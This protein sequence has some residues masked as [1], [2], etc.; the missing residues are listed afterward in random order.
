MSFW[1]NVIKE[2][3]YRGISRKELAFSLGMNNMTIH[4]AIERDSMPAADTAL[5]I[6]KTLGVS[7][8][9]LL[10]MPSESASENCDN[11]KAIA[12]YKKYS[13]VLERLE[14]LSQREI[15]AVSQLVAALSL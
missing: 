13:T 5:R 12:L 10:D 4:K 9:Y 11:E 2:L 3:E 15:S 8:E 7:L 1:K 6:A 14:T